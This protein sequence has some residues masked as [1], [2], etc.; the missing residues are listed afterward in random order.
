MKKIFVMGSINIDM[1]VSI[2]RFHLPGETI[3]G[4]GFST[5]TGGKG[6]NQAVAAARLGADVSLIGCVGQDDF[7]LRYIDI[8]R[9]EGIN[10]DGVMTVSGAPTGTALIEVA[11]SGDNR[12]AYVTGANGA[13]TSEKIDT[14]AQRLKEAD[15]FM[16]Q[17]ETPL[18]DAFH[19]AEIVKRAHGCVI[20]DPAPA[21]PLTQKQLRLCDFITPNETELALLTDMPVET[22]EDATKAAQ[23]L[24][25]DGAKAVLNKRGAQGA[26][27]VTAG[28]A[29]LYEGFQVNAIDTTAAGDSFNAGFAVGLSMGKTVG[30]S[31]RLAN[32]VGAL[33]TTAAGAQAAMPSLE[34]A[35]ALMRQG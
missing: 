10:T 1:T 4:T 5:Y 12:I 13:L 35:L 15:I 32:A 2:P 34:A 25:A 24:I 29:T 16:F 9:R 18:P 23:K 33:S 17:M 27:L 28:G 11:Q 7:G 19:A 14:Q 8:F 30:E 31:I 21:R 20:L 22:I 26:L 6:G 3:E